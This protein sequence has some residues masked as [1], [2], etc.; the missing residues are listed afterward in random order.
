[1]A[2][3]FFS[4]SPRMAQRLFFLDWLRILAFA[5]LVIYHVGMYYVLWDFH[6]KSP[7]ASAALHPWMKLTEPWRMSLIF[8]VSGAT[9]AHM[10]SRGVSWNLIRKR[11]RFLLLPLLCGIVLVVPPQSYFEV[12]QKFQYQGSYLDFLALYFSGYNGFCHAG[13]CLA[14]PTWNHLWFLPYLW[15]YTA[16]LCLVIAVSPAVLD[17]WAMV[18]QRALSGPLLLGL[19]IL[20]LFLAREALFRQFPSTH[21]LVGDWFNHAVYFAMFLA[22]AALATSSTMWSRFEQARWVALAIAAAFW[23]WLVMARPGGIAEHAVVATFQWSALV[24]CVGFAKCC[25]CRWKPL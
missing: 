4:P 3:Q 9:T 13:H 11:S 24:A 10:L 6:V 20:L 17:R 21:A 22:G 23:A 18:Y 25:R 15:C 2:R 14:L 7:N 1:M 8:M 16:L 12:V 19:P 5:A